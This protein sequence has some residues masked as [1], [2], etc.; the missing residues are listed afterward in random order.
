MKST[1]IIDDAV[2]SQYHNE[3]HE[4][5]LFQLRNCMWYCYGAMLQQVSGTVLLIGYATAGTGC[6]LNIVFF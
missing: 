5:G 6:S 3:V 1:F 4:Y 2:C